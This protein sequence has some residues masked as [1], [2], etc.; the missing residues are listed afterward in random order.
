MH[1][2]LIGGIAGAA[3]LF[4][5][6]AGF[7]LGAGTWPDP[8]GWL[9]RTADRA[10]A[11]FDDA[12]LAAPA[13]RKALYWKDPDGRNDFAPG[14]KKTT[15]GRD[16]IPVYDNEEADFATAEQKAPAPEHAGARKVIYY[17]NPMGLPDT[18][19]VPKK[20]W[21]GMDYIPVYEGEE[22]ESGTVKIS[23]DK[24]QKSGVRTAAVER[25]KLERI[26]RAPGVAKPDERTL[27]VVS[28][29]A[30]AFIEKLYVSETGRHVTAGEP[31][32]RIYSPDF[33]RALIDYRRD[34]NA[35][36][37]NAEQKLEILDVPKAVIAEAKRGRVSPSF[38]VPAPASG[39]VTEK[40]AVEGM[41]MKTGE[42]FYRLADLSSIWVVADVSEQ[43]IGQIKIGAPARVTFRAFLGE[44]YEGRVTFILH[45]LE[46][47]TRTAKV[48]IEV[49]NPDHRIKHEMFA[50][51]EIDAGANEPER[52]VV[53]ISAVID[54]G[55]RQV[56]L[57][58]RGEGRF[59]PRLVKPGVRGEGF[60]EIA[61]GVKDGEQVVVAANFLIDAESNLKA[62]LSSFTADS[63]AKH[64]AGDETTPLAGGSAP[65]PVR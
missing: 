53:P 55:N 16:Y 12:S 6:V 33:L 50:D 62:A 36:L 49:K 47:A 59:E 37:I 29:R 54:S 20:D 18:S 63:S 39:I 51:V 52:L 64:P 9:A 23:L 35:G 17:R 24:V 1:K 41:M 10:K 28:L 46:M 32:F 14:P 8:Q 58:D 56:V 13:E 5:A 40:P 42:P 2:L 26:I 44:T 38:D 25:R 11:T 57:V 43:D 3:I 61:E 48:R 60:V 4:A 65:E 19:P 34:V 21:M 31:L 15:D 27:R 22:E 7:R 45:E 30:D